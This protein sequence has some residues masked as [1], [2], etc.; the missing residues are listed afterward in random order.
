MLGPF[1]SVAAYCDEA[2]EGRFD[3][4]ADVLGPRLR[5]EPV[6]AEDARLAALTE[7]TTVLAPSP[8]RARLV[9]MRAATAPP[10]SRCQLA[11]HTGDGWFVEP[12]GALCA[13]R[14]DEGHCGTF[15]PT[16][17]TDFIATMPD[18]AHVWAT[19][20]T[21]RAA[22]TT[23]A[24]CRCLLVEGGPECTAWFGAGYFSH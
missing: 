22:V 17:T 1:D 2:A 18:S 16:R 6:H 7:H 14:C 19:I 11:L 21:E 20:E 4:P 5:C 12:E 13:S 8:V 9:H 23:T 24:H 3:G 15:S 10:S